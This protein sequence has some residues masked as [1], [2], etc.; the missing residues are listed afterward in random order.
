MLKEIQ[1]QE[2]SCYPANTTPKP[3]TH[4]NSNKNT[5]HYDRKSSSYDKNW[6]YAVRQAEVQLLDPV[7]D[8]LDPPQ[9]YEYDA[10]ETYDKGYYVAVVNTANKVE[11]WGCCFNCGKEG[12]R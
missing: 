7:R 9:S 12:H 3:S 8:E 6:T 10:S 11:L 5:T 2:D 4:D 1:E